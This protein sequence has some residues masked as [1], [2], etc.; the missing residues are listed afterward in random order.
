MKG[1]ILAAVFGTRLSEETGLKAKPM[2]EVGGQPKYSLKEE[3]RQVA[4]W[5]RARLLAMRGNALAAHA[6]PITPPL[7]KR[8]SGLRK[9]RVG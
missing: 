6:G 9:P 1:V 8:N 4:A 3:L 2:V 5:W 7:W